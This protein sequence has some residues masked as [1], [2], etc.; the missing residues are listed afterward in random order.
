MLA[1]LVAAV[2]AVAAGLV[3]REFYRR[4]EQPLQPPAVAAPSS[5]AVPS[6]GQ[7]GLP[8]VNATQDALQHPDYDEIRQLLQTHFDAINGRRYDRW[9]TTVT[10]ARIQVMPES[11]WREDYRSTKDGNI[12]IYRIE[13]APGNGLRV[14]VGFTS[15][16]NPE[17]AP[18]ELPQQCIRWHIVLPLVREDGQW[19]L[20]VSP[21]GASPRHEE[22]P[23]TDS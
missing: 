20:D 7:P 3:G 12:L 16:Q 1:V 19:K 4:S 17:D 18:P 14:L 22:C 8:N 10:K 2:F 9:K 21:A 11:K 13:A 5:G 15:T 6:G 23:M